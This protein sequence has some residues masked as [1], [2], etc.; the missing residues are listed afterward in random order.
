MST[1]FNFKR[2]WDEYVKPEFEKL[3]PEI[4]KALIATALEVDTI[5]QV[6][7]SGTVTGHSKELQAM[8]EAIPNSILARAAEVVYYYGHL[9]YG[10]QCQVGGL[11]WKFKALA[12]MTM[13][14]RKPPDGEVIHQA[15]AKMEK[16]LKDFH[17]HKEG[18][19]YDDE[20]LPAYLLSIA[21]DLEDSLIKIYKVDHVNHKPDMF[22]VG[23]SHFPEDGGMFIKPEQAPCCNCGQDYSA[24][25]SDRA[26]FLKPVIK[27]GDDLDSFF[28]SHQEAIQKVLKHITELCT[29]AKIK[30][31]G[32]A[33]IKP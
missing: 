24:H 23:T 26:M 27:D 4:H 17:D 33:F 21:P 30:L 32:F 29:A 19:E 16:A 14:N 2:A 25:T 3:S 6:D 20:E 12:S 28:K 9:A 18:T 13:I 15:K 7:A 31:D 5:S 8:F 10:K 1:E 11:Y 22:C